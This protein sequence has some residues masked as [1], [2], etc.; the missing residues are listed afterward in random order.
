[1][2]T[3]KPFSLSLSHTPPHAH[4]YTHTL[5]WWAR[6]VTQR[7]AIKKKERGERG[8]GW[9]VQNLQAADEFKVN[10][11]QCLYHLAILSWSVLG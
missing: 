7:S 9:K 8:G 4:T 11:P 3:F 2:Q 10:S 6:I 1:M 5:N